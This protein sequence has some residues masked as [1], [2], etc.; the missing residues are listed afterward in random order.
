[1]LEKDK[2]C[3]S[4]LVHEILKTKGQRAKNIK[5]KKKE[6]ESDQIYSYQRQGLG[7]GLI[8]ERLS[9]STNF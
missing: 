6:R 3:M 2:C 7:V 8:G 4:S 1:M 5:K 9:S